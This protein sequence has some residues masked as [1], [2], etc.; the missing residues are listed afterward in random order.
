MVRWLVSRLMGMIQGQRLGT[1]RV[2]TNHGAAV[3]HAA[4]GS[5]YGA[6][7]WV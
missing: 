1:V 7:V 6:A 2:G 3:G 4:N 5:D